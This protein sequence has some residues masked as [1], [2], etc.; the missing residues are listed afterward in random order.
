MQMTADMECLA[1][2]TDCSVVEEQMAALQPDIVLM[3]I[4]MPNVNGIEGL[5]RIRSQFPDVKV[6]M[7]TVF[8]ENEKI[9]DSIR[10]GAAGYILKTESPERILNAIRDVNNGGA[11]MTPSVAVKVLRYFHE[12]S[13]SQ[14]TDNYH[15]SEREKTVL[16]L[17]SDGNSYKMIA[18]QLGISYF[19]VNA[20]LK[21]IYEKLH[22][23][24]APEA[25]AIAYRNKLV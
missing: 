12:E 24:S 13:S 17:L 1:M 11:T 4:D 10:N 7:Q 3:D 22:V 8:E 20:H 23:H 21:A 25:I 19:T 6:L 15:L 2:F 14:N 18:G 5:K 16:K 9:F